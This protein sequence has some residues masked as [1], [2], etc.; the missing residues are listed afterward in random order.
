MI[1]VYLALLL[2][3]QLSEIQDF[4]FIGTCEY[5]FDHVGTLNLTKTHTYSG[6]GSISIDAEGNYLIADRRGAKA[7]LYTPA[8]DLKAEFGRSGRGPGDFEIPNS[9][10]R[11]SNEKVYISDVFGKITVL[12][13]GFSAFESVFSTNMMRI[14]NLM[15]LNEN[16]LI[17][18]GLRPNFIEEGKLIHILDKNSEEIAYSFFEKPELAKKYPHI[19]SQSERMVNIAIGKNKLALSHAL[20]SEIYIFND[21][22]DNKYSFKLELPEFNSIHNLKPVD[23]QDLSVFTKFS[24]VSVLGFLSEKTLVMQ[25]S[26]RLSMDPFQFES[27]D[28]YKTRTYII[29]LQNESYCHA[30]LDETIEYIDSNTKQIYT[31]SV[32]KRYIYNIYE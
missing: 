5:Q 14:S 11:A 21:S 2:N 17:F 32:S 27:E 8:G 12:N 29:D 31:S 16:H 7:L 18:Y 25:T 26:R 24:S 4:I 3:Y 6:W 20:E 23:F 28:S 1:L 19:I 10:V 13:P 9:I 22:L 15:E 30:D